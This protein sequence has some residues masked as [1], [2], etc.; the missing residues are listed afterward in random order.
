MKSVSLTLI[1][2]LF[3][4]SSIIPQTVNNNFLVAEN[5]DTSYTVNL[6]LSVNQNT[7]VL[8]NSVIR[9]SYDTTAFYFP[10]NPKANVDYQFYN[11]N[12]SNYYFTV[13]H[14]SS[15]IISVNLALM[16]STGTTISSNFKNIVSIHFK[17]I[18]QSDNANIQPV[19]R[20]FFR[21]HPNYGL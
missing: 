11:L 7:A 12:S 5:N 9:F 20:Q 10:Q 3:A 21:C 1:I 14:P 15:N 19:L 16:T 2:I 18:K 4:F 8:G 13:S 6:Q 17:K